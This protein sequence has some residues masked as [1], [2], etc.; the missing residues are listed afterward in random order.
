M[1]KDNENIYICS[2][3]GDK[4]DI[5]SF[6]ADIANKKEIMVKVSGQAYGN[7][8]RSFRTE[9]YRMLAILRFLFQFIWF[10]NIRTRSN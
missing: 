5:I 1:V 4:E 2:D 9:G 3:R 7:T 8:S 6:G 10:N